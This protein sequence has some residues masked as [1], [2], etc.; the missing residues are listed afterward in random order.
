MIHNLV[1]PKPGEPFRQK[2]LQVSGLSE[3]AARRYRYVK[4]QRN[5]WCYADVPNA[6]DLVY[7]N[8][9]PGSRGFAGRTLKFGLVDGGSVEFQGPWHSNP[10]ALYKDTGVDLRDK[11]ATWCCIGRARPSDGIDGIVWMD[12]EVQIGPFNRP[13]VEER[14]RLLAIEHDCVMFFHKETSGG[15]SNHGVFPTADGRAV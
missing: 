9:G 5:D 11:H 8:G 7:C 13:E 3:Q 1:I 4:G 2:Y 10:N 15:S 6:G 14:A 12:S